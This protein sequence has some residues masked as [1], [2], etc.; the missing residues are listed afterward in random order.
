MK[1]YDFP[2]AILFG[3]LHLWFSGRSQLRALKVMV[4]SIVLASVPTLFLLFKVLYAFEPNEILMNARFFQIFG[5]IVVLL[6]IFNTAY[7]QWRSVK[8]S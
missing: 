2:I 5:F 6:G 7:E 4:G 3:Y 8:T 1:V